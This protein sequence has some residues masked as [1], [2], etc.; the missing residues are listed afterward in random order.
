MEK[1]Q[2]KISLVILVL[3]IAFA[4]FFSMISFITD[5]M[6]FQEMGYVDVFLKQLVTQLTV[7]VPTFLIIT[8]LT[9]LYLNH[10]KKGYFKKI[11]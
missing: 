5:F 10:L 3:V 11:V 7:G 9:V 1:F 8:V 6:W 2:R 4:I